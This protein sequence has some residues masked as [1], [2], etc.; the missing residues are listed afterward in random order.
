M[1]SIFNAC[2]LL[3]HFNFSCGAHFDNGN[4]A[5]QFSNT[6]LQFFFVVVRSGI[7]N[8]L[9]NLSHTAL[10]CR[11]IAYAINNDG[12]VFVD[13]NTFRLTQIFQSS[14]FQFQTDLFRDNSTRSQGRDVLQHRFTTVAEARCFNRCNFNDTAHGVHYQSRQGFAFNVFC[15]DQQWLAGFR[16]GFQNWQHFTDVRDFLVSQ[17]NEWAFKFNRASFWFID[18]VRRQ[19]AAIE[20]HTFYNVQLVLQ[21]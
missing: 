14:F 10:D 13:N 4:A 19:V 1:Q 6:L 7:F 2:F 20:L 11:F 15:N 12:G 16:Y 21:A 8:L 5:S 18:E 9:T 3:F 17:Q